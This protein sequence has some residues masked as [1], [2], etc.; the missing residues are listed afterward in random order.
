MVFG[1]V[2]ADPHALRA[3]LAAVH[4]HVRRAVL[5][6]LVLAQ[7]VA[8]ENRVGLRTV[9]GTELTARRGADINVDIGNK[10]HAG[11]LF[12]GSAGG[13]LGS[14]QIV[15]LLRLSSLFNAPA[16]FLSVVPTSLDHGNILLYQF[17]FLFELSFHNAVEKNI[18]VIKAGWDYAEEHGW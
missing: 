6:P 16:V 18:A 3:T 7:I 9:L 10:I 4:R 8:I 5:E 2:V 13:S 1:H 11:L 17:L 14:G 12:L 15:D